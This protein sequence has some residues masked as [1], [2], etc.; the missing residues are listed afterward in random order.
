MQAPSH[1]AEVRKTSR[2]AQLLL[3]GLGAQVGGLE[4]SAAAWVGAI[5]VACVVLLLLSGS[6]LIAAIPVLAT[7]VLFLVWTKPLRYTL[8]VFLFASFAVFDPPRGPT[9][10]SLASGVLWD[11]LIRPANQFLSVY[12]SGLTGIGAFALTGQEFVLIL[13]FLLVVV[14]TLRGVKIDSAGRL[15]SAKVLVA[16]VLVEL[17][18]VLM[19]ELWGT[20]RGGNPR[21]SLFQFRTLLWLP[22]LTM[23]VSYCLR[24][25]RDFL[26]VAM[27]ATVAAC[28]KIAIG[29]YFII[30][31]AWSNGIR[32]EAMTG[33]HD[34]V[35]Y[36]SVLFFWCVAL[37]QQRHARRLLPTIMI[38][39][40]IGAGIFVNSRRIAYLSLVAS[41]VVY[42]ALLQ[43]PVKRRIKKVVICALPVLAIYLLLA[44]THSSGIFAPGAQLMQISDLRDPSSIWRELEN[45]N[46]IFTLSQHPLLG[47]GWGHEYYEIV[48][49]P[50]ISKYMPQYRLM[51]HNGVIWLLGIGGMVG[52]VMLW[53]P[54]VVGVYLATRSY[55][56]AR[57]PFEKIA[58]VS[59]LAVI[60]AY[61]NQAWGDMGVAG[62][63]PMILLSCALALT[64]KLALATGAWPAGARLFASP[65]AKDLARRTD[66]TSRRRTP[67]VA[68]T[69]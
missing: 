13:L 10:E 41:F 67:E 43:G 4:R 23:V 8:F 59:A 65:V 6:A 58:A 57:D 39:A 37:L 34:S 15:P 64:G 49:L 40:W 26:S 55:Y 9:G 21:A 5:V 7:G 44:R 35:L 28:V 54:I 53:M 31:D 36:V 25:P 46:L 47:S 17:V 12:L 2:P 30:N 56:A 48:R 69:T 24:G 45:R 1:H 42:Y 68:G 22:I 27:L 18:A 50:D 11:Y 20:I 29:L 60:V 63:L 66:S 38:V 51:P 62:P 32:P 33:H 16:F 3:R 19:L 14:R 52:F 61:V